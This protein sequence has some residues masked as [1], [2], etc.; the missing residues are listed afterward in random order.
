MD[1]ASKITQ[2]YKDIEAYKAAVEDATSALAAAERELDDELDE[3]Y[4][5]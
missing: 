2:L 3:Y 4:T 1:Q 5:E